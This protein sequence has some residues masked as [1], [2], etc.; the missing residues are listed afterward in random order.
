MPS[1]HQPSRPPSPPS[2]PCHPRLAIPHPETTSEKNARH[3]RKLKKCGGLIPGCLL[4]HPVRKVDDPSPES[5]DI[6]IQFYGESQYYWMPREGLVCMTVQD[7]DGKLRQRFFAQKVLPPHKWDSDS[8]E[9][10][11]GEDEEWE[12]EDGED[13]EDGERQEGENGEED[14][15]EGF[16]LETAEWVV[17]SEVVKVVA[18]ILVF[19][20]FVV[21]GWPG[22]RV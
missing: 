3:Y 1:R 4:L 22:A 13:G 6:R 5:D 20:V 11:E 17:D 15:A 8:E 2:P 19:A 21:V 12:G 10:R 16:L 18:A 14:R 7:L 9:E